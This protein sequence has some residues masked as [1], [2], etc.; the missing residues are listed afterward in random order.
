[1]A[2]LEQVWSTIDAT[3]KKVSPRAAA[4][5]RKPAT[6][7]ALAAL[8]QALKVKLPADLRTLLSLHDG[9]DEKK[10][11]PVLF[12]KTTWFLLPAASIV[13]TYESLNEL[14]ADGEF[15]DLEGT[16]QDGLVKPL[17]WSDAWIPFATNAAGDSLCVDAGPTKKGKVGQLLWWYHDEDFR[18]REAEH[19][20]AFFGDYAKA[21][22]TGKLTVRADG[23]ISDS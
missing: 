18:E 19:L 21:L 23:A 17:W 16:N 11:L 5:L 22:S 12:A 13:S 3:L 8:E 1:M 7:K 2:S 15:D 14:D 20:T 10:R 9:Q 4:T 6:D